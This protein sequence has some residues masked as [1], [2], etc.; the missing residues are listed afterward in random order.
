MKICNLSPYS[1]NIQSPEYIIHLRKNSSLISSLISTLVSEINEAENT[2]QEYIEQLVHMVV[3]VMEKKIKASLPRDIEL[4]VDQKTVNIL[5]YIHLNIFDPK[6]LTIQEMSKKFFISPAYLGRYFKSYTNQ[7]LHHY[8]LLYKI[9]LIESR[10]KDSNMRIN[11]IADEFGFSDKSYLNKIFIKY[12]GI[13]PMQ[14]RNQS[15]GLFT[16]TYDAVYS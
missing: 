3:K 1:G 7:N 13:S 12:K 9:K 15:K 4:N 5:H 14:Y 10:L 8:I 6:K 2:S 11:E 16:K